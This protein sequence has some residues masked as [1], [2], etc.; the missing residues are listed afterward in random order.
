MCSGYIPTLLRNN[1]KSQFGHCETQV[2]RDSSKCQVSCSIF[3]KRPGSPHPCLVCGEDVDETPSLGRQYK[4]D[5][6]TPRKAPRD[7]TIVILCV[8][9]PYREYPFSY[10][11]VRRPLTHSYTYFPLLWPIQIFWEN[12]R[13]VRAHCAGKGVH[14]SNKFSNLTAV[15]EEHVGVSTETKRCCRVSVDAV[16]GLLKKRQ[17]PPRPCL[18]CGE[19]VG[20]TPSLGR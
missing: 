16:V 18:V 19:D 20:E 8:P 3:K 17:G 7:S 1:G 12:L 4:E 10:V 2:Y 14:L 13:A 11:N 15:R 6:G 5:D 9:Y